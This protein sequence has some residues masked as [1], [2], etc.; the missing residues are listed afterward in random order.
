MEEWA[1]EDQLPHQ[2]L[3]IEEIVS[4]NEEKLNWNCGKYPLEQNYNK[5]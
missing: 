2:E 5:H 3:N 1:L 4:E